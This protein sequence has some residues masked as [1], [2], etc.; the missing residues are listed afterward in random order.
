M[1]AVDTAVGG[2]VGS[3]ITSVSFLT[4]HICHGVV[5]FLSL[6]WNIATTNLCCSFCMVWASAGVAW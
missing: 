6:M 2:L 4:T 1:V 5:L 3:Q